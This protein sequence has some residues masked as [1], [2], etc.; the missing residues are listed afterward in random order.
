M[1]SGQSRRDWP[2]RILCLDYRDKALARLIIGRLVAEVGVVKL[3]VV[4][5]LLH[6]RGVI[7]LLHN[8]AEVEYDDAVGAADGGEAMRDQDG[9]ALLQDQ[10]KPLLNLRLGERVNAG[11]SFI[12]DDDGRV[13]QQDARQ[14]NKLA[15]P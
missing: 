12:E 8:F 7:A 3:R 13:L 2:D 4:A 14:G 10:I 5:A 1:R 15:L 9:S 11:C 6:Q